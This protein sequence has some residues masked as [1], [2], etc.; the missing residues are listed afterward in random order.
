MDGWK[1]QGMVGTELVPVDIYDPGKPRL[2]GIIE[3]EVTTND[4]YQ[5]IATGDSCLLLM[6]AK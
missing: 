5:H 4:L 1:V 3:S 6:R 2:N